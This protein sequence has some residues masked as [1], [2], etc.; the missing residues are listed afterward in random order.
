MLLA[1]V[2]LPMRLLLIVGLP[3]GHLDAG[4]TGGNRGSLNHWQ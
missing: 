2:L 4:S 3:A 1:V